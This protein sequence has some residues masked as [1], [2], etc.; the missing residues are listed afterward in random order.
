MSHTDT[1]DT[2]GSERYLEPAVPLLSFGTT[3]AGILLWQAGIQISF[4]YF[5]AGCLAASCILAYLAWCRPRKDIVALS[6]P[7]YAF[8]FFVVPADY[9]TALV[10][11]L[12][13][14]ASLT[15]LLVRLK[16]RFSDAGHL[17]GSDT[18]LTGPLRVYVDRLPGAC[19]VLS[20]QQSRGVGAVI[21]RFSTGEYA[22][23][24]R[25]A[26]QTRGELEGVAGLECLRLALAI[27]SEQAGVTEGGGLPTPEEFT[28]FP[29]GQEALLA[30]PVMAGMDRERLYMTTLWN[31][32]LLLFA[33]AWLALPADPDLLACRNFAQNL[34]GTM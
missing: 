24:A 20:Q 21:V 26:D 30:H 18:A 12:L 14:A 31:A 7:L 15:I 13:C 17:R 28:T 10:L 8:I 3:F 11:Q 6:T 23:A 4:Q 16:Y 5:A 9:T 32:L 2:R 27:V 25:L 33:A 22:A 29:P 1:S 19:P 34:A